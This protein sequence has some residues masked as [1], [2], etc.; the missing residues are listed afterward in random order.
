MEALNEI[1]CFCNRKTNGCPCGYY[2]FEYEKNYCRCSPSQVKK[3]RSRIS[4]PILDRIDLYVPV[5][6]VKPDEFKG[7]KKGESSEKIRER[8]IK[9]WEIQQKRFSNLPISFNSQMGRK[10]IRELSEVSP[11]AEELLITASKTLGL[12]ARSFD[13]VLKVSRTIADLE[14][15]VSV[16][17]HHVAEALSFREES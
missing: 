15:S 11:E 8:V 13:R 2:G 12:S 7:S 6:A 5:P 9:A 16:E 1:L 3:Y 10:E 14:G 4:G 17:P